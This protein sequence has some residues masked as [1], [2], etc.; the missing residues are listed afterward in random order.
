MR[1]SMLIQPSLSRRSTPSGR[2]ASEPIKVLHCLGYMW[3][4]GTQLRT[5]DVFRHVDRRR[6][7]FH[8]CSLSGCPGEL[9]EEVRALG[10]QVHLLRQSRP[11]FPRRFRELLRR[12][13]FDVVHSH[14]HYVSGHILRL[15]AQCGTPLRVAHFRSSHT[16]PVPGWRRRPCYMLRR[17]LADRCVTQSMMRRWIDLYATNILG[18]SQWALTRAWSPAW[19]SD[20]RCQVVYDGLETSPFAGKPDSD[21]V[22]REFGLPKDGPLYIHVG[23]MAEAKNHPRLISVFSALLRRQPRARLLLVGRSEKT[24]EDVLRQQIAAEGIADGVT[25]VGERTDVPRLLK[26]ADLLVFPSLFEGLGDAVL[27]ACA[28]GTPTLASSLPS[29]HE[30]AAQ[31]PGVR[32]L[33]L[34]EPDARWADVAVEMTNT[35]PADRQRQAALQAFSRSPFTAENCTQALC[36]IWQEARAERRGIGTADG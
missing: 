21:S 7:Q 4:A 15:A 8:V 14:V 35:R 16:D 27:E 29:I 25:F 11:S 2:A 5:L 28:V 20:P 26:A 36:R 13:Q 10:G 19:P 24:I 34:D 1:S 6:F 33:S 30:I 18:V 23:R 12:H 17:L 22:R 3:R 31:L 9:D 32:C